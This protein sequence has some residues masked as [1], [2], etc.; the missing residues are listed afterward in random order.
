MELLPHVSTLAGLTMEQLEFDAI[1]WFLQ[2]AQ[3]AHQMIQYAYRV[4]QINMKEDL[5]FAPVV[6][7]HQCAP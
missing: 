6:A 4:D 2:E 1:T 5:K 3:L 7:G